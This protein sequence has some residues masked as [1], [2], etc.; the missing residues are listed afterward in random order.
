MAPAACGIDCTVCRLFGLGICSPCGPG[1]SREAELKLEAQKRLLGAPCPVLAC[2]RMSQ[3]AF[4][5]K[6][7]AFFPCENFASGPYP[8]SRGFLEMQQRRR[9]EASPG[10]T[11]SGDAV[12]I[13]G[14]HWETLAR[15]PIEALCLSAGA[16][17]SC[18]GE[19]R[20]AFLQETLRV[21]LNRR[22]VFR[23]A[24]ISWERVRDPML[25]LVCLVY[26]AGAR[27]VPIG[28]RMVGVN[29]LKNAH[30]FRGPHALD[31]DPILR[32]F[33]Q[34]LPG[35]CRAAEALGG[36]PLELADGAFALRAFP[37]IPLYYLL[38][39]GDEEFSPRMSVLFDETVE[40]HLPA[41]ALWGL[42]NLVSH[43]LL[44]ADSPT[45]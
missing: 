41:D 1:T 12:R 38:W 13:P 33:G 3:V 2:A 18:P 16:S 8:F 35:F 17:S 21:D 7:C 20:I 37:R 39:E 40:T 23:K 25:E 31:L 4:C 10:K 11:P 42:V 22:L 28:G 36:K 24:K 9:G 34:D 27:D 14:E 29:E 43:R 45:A 30:F 5:L 19:I 44:T 26:L 32:R 15:T 6:D